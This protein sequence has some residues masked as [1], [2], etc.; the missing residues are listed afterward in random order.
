MSKDPT[1]KPQLPEDPERTLDLDATVS[2]DPSSGSSDP[3]DMPTAIGPYHII[4]RLGEGGMGEVFLAQQT[5]PIKRLVALKII[6]QG[7]DTR[8]VVARFEAERQVLARL[9]HPNI[10][11]VHDAGAIDRGR[12]PSS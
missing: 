11:R 10:A 2:S 7:M 5:E 12:S 9:D 8:Q 6:K 4:R 1:G 3:A